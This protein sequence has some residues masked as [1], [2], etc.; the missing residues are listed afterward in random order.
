[1]DMLVLE[2]DQGEEENYGIKNK[3]NY[4]ILILFKF[5]CLNIGN[6]YEF[7]QFWK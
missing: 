7:F 5:S 3:R 4:K 2:V 1:M 6:Y